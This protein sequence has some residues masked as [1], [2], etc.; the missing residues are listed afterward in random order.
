MRKPWN[1]MH[2]EYPPCQRACDHCGAYAITKNKYRVVLIDYDKCIG[3][4]YCVAACP[5]GVPQFN[6]TL[7]YLY[8]KEEKTPYEKIAYAKRYPV[9]QK[10]ANVVEKCTFCWHKLEKA[11]NSGQIHMVGRVPE[12]TPSCDLVCPV[13]ARFFGNIE[14]PNSNVSQ[15]I[16]TKKATQLKKEFGT[17]PLVYYVLEGGDY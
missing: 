9:H 15:V 1:C 5:Y 2:C 7:K 10:K 14:D 12:Y 6:E 16:G 17:R 8:P 13:N 11:I 4:N 3:C